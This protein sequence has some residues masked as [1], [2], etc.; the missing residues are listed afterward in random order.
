MQE[1]KGGRIVLLLFMAAVLIYT[2]W[3]FMQGGAG[4]P[5]LVITLFIAATT[6]TRIVKS[7]IDDFRG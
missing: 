6:G 4:V 7:L 3:N 2:I 1:S 5:T